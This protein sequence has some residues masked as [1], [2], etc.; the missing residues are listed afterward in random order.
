MLSGGIQCSAGSLTGATALAEWNTTLT[1][2]G[3]IRSSAGSGTI[4]T[5]VGK[6][7]NRELVSI[8]A[9]LKHNITVSKL[10]DL[11]EN[12]LLCSL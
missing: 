10:N 8:R 1:G 7:S 9:V 12:P 2:L 11:L 5:R 6:I 3:V 4:V